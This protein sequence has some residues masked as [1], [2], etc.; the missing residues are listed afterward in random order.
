MSSK[1]MTDT[2]EIR[3]HMVAGQ[4]QS[5]VFDIAKDKFVASYR[6]RESAYAWAFGY[7]SE[8]VRA[9]DS[10]VARLTEANSAL[11]KSMSR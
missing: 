11:N 6:D 9:L 5:G 2:L 4:W 1:P 3:P 10:D 8:R 7:L